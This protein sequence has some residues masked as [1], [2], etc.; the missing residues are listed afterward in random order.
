M[1]YQSRPKKSPFSGA[2]LLLGVF[3]LLSIG[4]VILPIPLGALGILFASLAHRKGK[5]REISCIVGLTSSIIGLIASISIMVSSIAMIPTLMKNPEYREQLNTISEQ[6]YG[7]SFDDVV[8]ELYGVE[9]D[10]IFKY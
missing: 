10:D 4:I 2:A 9:L 1:D 7:K 8:E 3:S 5:K 6:L